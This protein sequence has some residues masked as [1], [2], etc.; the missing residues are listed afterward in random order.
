[1][2]GIIERADGLGAFAGIQGK[3]EMVEEWTGVPRLGLG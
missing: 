2:L 1:L 3:V